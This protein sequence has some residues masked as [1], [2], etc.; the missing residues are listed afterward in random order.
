ML[1]RLV[2]NQSHVLAL[3]LSPILSLLLST[4]PARAEC[5]GDDLIAALAA[6][7]RAD[8]DAVAAGHAYADGNLWRATK[9]GSTV[10]VVGTLHLYDPRMDAMMQTI[11]PLIEAAD[12][13]LVEAGREEIAALQ[14]AVAARPELLFRP[15]GPTLPEVLS[16][17]EWQAL[18]A[19]LKARGIPPF[20]ASKFQPW[21][22]SMLL[23][24]PACAMD[25]L[26][27]AS[28]GLDEL[29][30]RRAEAAGVPIR[31][32]EPY[33]TVFRIFA[34][35]S[36]EDQLDMIRVSLAAAQAAD[37]QFATLIAAYFAG[38]HRLIWEFTRAQAAQ[39][40]G[41]DPAKLEQD[42]LLMERALLTGRNQ[43]WMA[44]LQPAV[45][46]ADVVV[47]VGAAHLSGDLGVLNLLA[48]SGYELTRLPL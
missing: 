33:D 40:P 21:Y 45:E 30:M 4:Q 39:L 20:L 22:V 17:P 15:T 35:L 44:V 47:A 32:L 14:S 46:G 19:E 16:K 28:S 18:S 9:P 27:S 36:L 26:Q 42:F 2:P 8:L 1:V 48:K 23:G 37:D 6:G 31:A 13:V 5:R 10:Y 43:S 41:I 11:A 12:L 7:D 25:Q 24:L 3:I 29:I 34:D 38:K